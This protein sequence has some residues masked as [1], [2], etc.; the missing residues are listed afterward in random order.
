MKV[1]NGIAAVCSITA[2]AFS[3]WWAYVTAASGD[4]HKV[5]AFILA[6]AVVGMSAIICI[7]LYRA[8]Q[9]AGS[10][11]PNVATA[12]KY[13]PQAARKV[14]SWCDEMAAD[15]AE[16][17]G[18]RVF[19]IWDQPQ[20]F[21]FGVADPFI[22][23]RVTFVNGT[24]FTLISENGVEGETLYSGQPLRDT[25]KIVN[26]SKLAPLVLKHG[27]KIPMTIRQPLSREVAQRLN[28]Q[29]GHVKLDFSKTW[30]TFRVEGLR[31]PE[32]FRLFGNDDVTVANRD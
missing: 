13:A 29:R 20:P 26:Q 1:I 16:K 5:F 10:G 32:K 6:A 28:E 2:L 4:Q 27:A 9:L 17:I 25:P 22:T 21:Y 19:A 31:A 18:E 3:F 15:D 24:I 11:A 12:E 14:P 30:I 8:S 23:F 7:T